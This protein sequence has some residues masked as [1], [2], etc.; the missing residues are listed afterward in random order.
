[1]YVMNVIQDKEFH[2]SLEKVSSQSCEPLGTSLAAGYM[3]PVGC[4][5]DTPLLSSDVVNFGLDGIF[6]GTALEDTEDSCLADLFKA[7]DQFFGFPIDVEQVLQDKLNVVFGIG[8][9]LKYNELI[10]GSSDETKVIK[11]WN[12]I[13]IY[14]VSSLSFNRVFVGKLHSLY[15][16]FGNFSF[17]ILLVWQWLKTSMSDIFLEWKRIGV[18]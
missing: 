18:G 7:D 3:G 1:M 17:T 12:P 5:I 11:I 2:G 15:S 4:E 13:C 14:F 9:C 6:L 16:E 10:V 8:N